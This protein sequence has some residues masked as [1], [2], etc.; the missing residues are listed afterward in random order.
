M[1]GFRPFSPLTFR[2]VAN[3]VQQSSGPLTKILPLVELEDTGAGNVILSASGVGVLVYSNPDNPP[4]VGITGGV[5]G[6]LLVLFSF[7]DCTLVNQSAGASPGQKIFTPGGVDFLLVAGSVAVLEYL[8]Y[9]SGAG[10]WAV[11]AISSFDSKYPS[12]QFT[13]KAVSMRG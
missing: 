7:E 6:Q 13:F 3:V 8:L 1:R 2:R 12:F 11:L 4:I 10:E 5:E 9:A